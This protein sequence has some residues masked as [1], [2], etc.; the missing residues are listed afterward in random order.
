MEKNPNLRVII[1]HEKSAD[2]KGYLGSEDYFTDVTPSDYSHF[3][4][5]WL[6]DTTGMPDKRDTELWA[7][8]NFTDPS[9]KPGEADPDRQ[10]NSLQDLRLSLKSVRFA[11]WVKK[12]STS[13]PSE[14][15]AWLAANLLPH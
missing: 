14:A 3:Y 13:N 9:I 5:A 1:A 7:I 10:G 11:D 12:H 2:E 15:G 6:Y 8:L 4:K